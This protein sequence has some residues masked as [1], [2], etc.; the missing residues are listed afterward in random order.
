MRCIHHQ[1]AAFNTSPADAA[2]S[3]VGAAR[4]WRK[5]ALAAMLHAA[6]PMGTEVSACAEAGLCAVHLCLGA[7]RRP[8]A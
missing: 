6:N 1:P 2:T 4:A 3:P 5:D 8:L 7:H